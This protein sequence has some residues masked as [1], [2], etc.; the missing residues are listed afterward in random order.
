MRKMT[1]LQWLTLEYALEHHLI[2]IQM[3]G[4]T[5]NPVMLM[6]I[7]LCQECA[8]RR[9]QAFPQT[10]DSCQMR[11]VEQEKNQESE[12]AVKKRL[13][14]CQQSKMNQSHRCLESVQNKMKKAKWIL[15]L[16]NFKTLTKILG[17]L[18]KVKRQVMLK[19]VLC[20]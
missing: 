7:M 10:M 2:G 12:G 5:S 14:I 18:A 17:I 8:A 6:H 20:L 16:Q 1:M 15:R 13:N 9:K 19:R 4:I 11:K 3:K